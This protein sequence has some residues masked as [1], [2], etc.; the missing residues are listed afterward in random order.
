MSQNSTSPALLQIEHASKSYNG[1]PALMDAELTL[2]SGEV[3]A[4]IGENGAGKST[5]IKLLAGVVAA[6]QFDV[7]M[8]GEPVKISSPQTATALGLRFIHQELNVVRTLSVAENIFTNQ[9]YPSIIGTFVNWRALYKEARDI[10]SATGITHINPREMMSRLSPGDQMLVKIA[11]AFTGMQSGETANVYVMDEPTA[12]LTGEEAATLFRV[13]DRLKSQGCAILYVSHR[14]DEIFAIAQKVTVM[15]DG[16][17]ITTQNIEN[18]SPPELIQLMTG[19]DLKHVYPARDLP[20]PETILLDVHGLSTHAVHNISFSVRHG[21]IVGIAGLNGSGRTELLRAI[22]GADRLT[23]GSITLDGDAISLNSPTQAWKRGIALV[24]EERRSQGLV[25]SRSIA[26]NISLPHL[27]DFSFGGAFL[28]HRLERNISQESG[29]TVKL[30]ATGTDQTVRELSGGNQQKV[31]FARALVKTPKVLLLDEPTR[32]VDVGAKYDI[33]ALIRQI[34]AQGTGILMVSSE[35]P[36]LLGMCDR[37]LV[38]KDGQMIAEVSPEGMSEGD[39][40]MLCYGQRYVN[41]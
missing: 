7:S 13:I 40:L 16:R 38:L 2:H 15:R 39:L 17:V 28:N 25:I 11:S 37:I 21:E 14:L 35:L 19:R 27:H 20:Y 41:G 6:D 29:E 30:K 3:H 32:G 18:T 31:V 24:P 12:S 5:L 10:L 22:G 36:E 33:Y 26:D 1:V 34:S 4:L 23:G 9:P 8:R